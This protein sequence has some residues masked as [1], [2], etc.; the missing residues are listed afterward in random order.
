MT[1]V[2]LQVIPSVPEN[3]R[4]LMKTGGGSPMVSSTKEQTVIASWPLVGTDSSLLTGHMPRYPTQRLKRSTDREISKAVAHWECHG[5][6]PACQPLDSRQRRSQSTLHIG[7]MRN[8][9]PSLGKLWPVVKEATLCICT[10]LLQH[11]LVMMVNV[12]CRLYAHS[13]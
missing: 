1:K 11:L 5:C 3:T 7:N 2:L 4:Y 10:T 8:C 9:Y 6:Q 12:H 13:G